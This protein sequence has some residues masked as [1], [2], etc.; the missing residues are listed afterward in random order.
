LEIA[1]VM[2]KMVKAG[3]KP[4]RSILFA[5]WDAQEFGC[6][7][8]TEYVEEYQALLSQ[9]AIAYINLDLSIAGV[10]FEVK[11]S[12]SLTAVMRE[13][14]ARGSAYDRTV[15]QSWL[16]TTQ[17]TISSAASEPA[18]SP[19]GGGSD[20]VG[21][22]HYLGIPSIYPR[23]ANESRFPQ[24]HS[25]FDSYTWI[26][27]F[28]DP[29][30]QRHV[31]VAKVLGNLLIRFAQSKVL[32]FDYTQYG[33][34]LSFFTGRIQGMNENAP[35]DFGALHDAVSNFQAAAQAAQERSN[36]IENGASVSEAEIHEWNDR[37]VSIEKAFLS[38]R[39]GSH[40]RHTIFSQ[41]V[42]GNFY[43]SSTFPALTEQMIQTNWEGAQVEIARLAQVINGAA[44]SLRG[45]W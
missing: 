34:D 15:Y 43:G 24:Y 35:L 25:I 37:L 39:S 6:I 45:S 18:L 17:R 31:A 28:T 16:S 38:P 22:F 7:G 14:S 10:E 42:T 26:T 4:Q 13:V 40:F 21:F 33:A 32:P 9:Q 41:D 5:S 20:H 23:Y 12:P 11:G 36:D 1:R 2:G 8:S 44:A 30:F 3:W 19:L 29:A 27:R